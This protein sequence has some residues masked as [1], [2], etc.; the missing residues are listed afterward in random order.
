MKKTGKLFGITAIILTAA[1]IFASCG[2]PGGGP[3]NVTPAARTQP[4]S[5]VSDGKTYSLLITENTNIKRA[6]FSIT[7]GDY[8][9]LTIS[10][11][12]VSKGEVL[13]FVNSVFQLESDKSNTFIVNV[14][15]TSI[16]SFN[17]SITW[18][19]DEKNVTETFSSSIVPDASGNP[20]ETAHTHSWEFLAVTLHATCVSEGSR[21]LTCKTCGLNKTEVIAID[22]DAHEWIQL[23]GT[24]STCTVHGSGKRKCDLCDIEETGSFFELD[25]NV[26]NWITGEV[27]APACTTAGYTTQV[28]SWCSAQ[29]HINP[30]NA[31]GHIMGGWTV[32]TAPTCTAAG[33]ETD[34]CTR[35]GCDHSATRAIAALEHNFQWVITAYA[36][37]ANNGVE[38]STEIC[39]ICS[40][41]G[42]IQTTTPGLAF[43]LINNSTAYEV[44]KGTVSTG[45]VV[46]PSTY[47]SRPVT[48]IGSSAFYACSGLTSI[49]IPDSVTS[50]GNYAFQYCSSLTSVTI[51]NS[52]TSIGNYAFYVCSG[53]TSITIPNS[54]TSIGDGAFNNCRGLTSITIPNSVTSIGNRAFSGCTGLT[55]ITIPNSVTS[56]GNYAFQYCSS[57]TSITIPDSV[58]TIGGGAFSGCTSLIN[59][60][61]DTNNPNYSAQNNILYNKTKTEIIAWPTASGNVTIPN[62]V[63]SIGAG[64]FYGCSG[65]T[66][67]TIG[68]S[69]TIIGNSAF[70]GCT[71]L[72]SITIPNSVTSIG[73]GAFGYLTGLTSVTFAAGSQ[74]QSIGDAAFDNCTGLTG[75]FTIPAGVTS[76][77]SAAFQK[78]GNLTSLV[79]AAGSQLQSIGDFAFSLCSG[80]TGSL[81]IPAGVTFID[82]L[83][84]QNCSGLT[85]VTI[86]SGV[87]SIGSEAFIRCSGLT[88]I[89]VDAANPNYSSQDGILYNKTKTTL[90]QAPGALSGSFTTPNSVNS[91]GYGAFEGCSGLTS[92]TIPNS[93]TSIGY[94][95]FRHCT[96]LTSITIPN[97]VT[98]IGNYAFQYCSSLTSVTFLGTIASGNFSSIYSFDGDLRVKYLSGGVGTYKR[99][100]GGTVWTKQ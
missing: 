41:T 72:T 87:T 29:E 15:G 18:T 86:G 95:A 34:A 39:Q 13:S 35:T 12:K 43:T 20:G 61:V 42:N 45:A 40:A 19:Y 7:G 10:D 23:E 70:S 2:D 76:I 3:A 97:S 58:I 60:I 32:T 17:G 92:I 67:V 48:S 54:V 69:V 62:S 96:G 14:S 37:P 51:P 50:I 99:A 80:L 68:N 82:R 90:I 74:L 77:G 83:A 93:V 71:S 63:T 28:C 89:N 88:S 79:F 26:H 78:C 52:V 24:P 91:I 100:A 8:Y 47:N 73:W 49:T 1:F 44:K 65:L 56:I 6:T 30:V 11:G 36:A 64:A 27:T 66:S 25:E 33:I 38:T 81:T 75:A 59:F 5:A 85:S 9:T 22:A 31:L 98:S 21:T 57:L 84:F 53:L 94:E 55:S 46:I 4:F 16:S